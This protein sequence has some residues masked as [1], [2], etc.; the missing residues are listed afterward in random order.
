MGRFQDPHGRYLDLRS[1]RALIIDD[2]GPM[3]QILRTVLDAIGVRSISEARTAQEAS[4]L[5]QAASFDLILLDQV[6]SGDR[7]WALAR[8]IRTSNGPN[9]ERPIIMVSGDAHSQTILQ[10]RDAGVDEFVVKPVSVGTLA[11]RIEAVLTRPREFVEARTY[12]GPDR[13]RRR[14]AQYQGPERRRA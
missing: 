14:R 2:N 3:L 1:V 11:E 5:L 12:T 4:T 6:L 10:A 7:G 8:E 9:R 13:R